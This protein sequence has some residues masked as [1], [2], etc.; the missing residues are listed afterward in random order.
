MADFDVRVSAPH[1]AAGTAASSRTAGRSQGVLLALISCLPVLGAVL[2]A[3]VLP[4][5]QDYFANTPGA[6]VLVPVSL[7]VPALMVGVLAPFAGSLV[8]RFGRKRLLVGSLVVY[9]VF[10][11]APLWL[12]GL[13][14]IVISRAGVGITEAAIM[15]CCTTLIAD[16]FT[17]PARDRW[18]GLQTLSAAVAATLFF[19]LGG[20]LGSVSWR[21]PTVLYASGLVFAVLA[22]KL[23]WQP[24]PA[25]GAPAVVPP[26]PWRGLAAPSL[27]TLVGGVV[28]YAPIVELAYVLDGIGVTS[29]GVIGAVTTLSSAATA[30]GAFVF[31][32]VAARGTG[33]LL[34]VA[35]GLAGAGL[36]IIG[37]GGSLAIIAV[38]AVIACA[39]TGLLLPTLLTWAVAPL[40]FAQRGRGTGLWTASLSLG[41]F[42]CPLLVLAVEGALGGLPAAVVLIGVVALLLAAG[43]LAAFRRTITR[44]AFPIL[45]VSTDKE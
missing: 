23:L 26:V 37:T 22:A 36:V 9:A 44:P 20:A 32:R 28:F 29:V 8:D 13:V 31:G 2:L 30:T 19:A 12:T 1:P 17:G 43:S 4:R 34:P 39:G 42:L 41:Q 5:M 27:V 18:L 33:T 25:G 15:T 24:R 21:I 3:P 6:A 40:D 45:N 16:Y 7:T 14:P 11:T 38:G 35:F 10:G